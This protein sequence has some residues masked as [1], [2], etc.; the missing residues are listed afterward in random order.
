MSIDV[1]EHVF[2]LHRELVVD[3]YL[4]VA[5]HDMVMV[6]VFDGEKDL[7]E[8]QSRRVLRESPAVVQVIEQLPSR[9][10]VQ[11]QVQIMRLLTWLNRFLT[12]WNA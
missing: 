3:Q 12:V 7:C 2:R 1:E 4:E 11:N 6:E 9:T 10:E 5:I 8:V